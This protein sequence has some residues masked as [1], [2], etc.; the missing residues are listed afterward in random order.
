LSQMANSASMIRNAVDFDVDK[1]QTP[2][3]ATIKR[4]AD[5]ITEK[6]DGDGEDSGKGLREMVL[7]TIRYYRDHTLLGHVY[8]Q[9]IVLINTLSCFQ[10]I[11]L[12][13]TSVDTN[14]ASALYYTFFYVELVVA[15]LFVF[16]F[17]LSMLSSD[18]FL[19]FF[20]SFDCAIDLMTFIPVFATYDVQCPSFHEIGS[21][22]A[23]VYFILCAMTTTRILR[24]IKFRK[25]FFAIEDEVQ[26]FLADMGLKIGVMI[27]FSKQLTV[28]VTGML[29]VTIVPFMVRCGTGAVPR[30]RAGPALPHM[31]VAAV[32]T[33]F[34]C[35]TLLTI[36]LLFAQG[37]T[38]C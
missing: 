32:D 9:F 21:P 33:D 5:Q 26:R 36:A 3:D 15:C 31:Y 18:S 37:C 28:T 11:Y 6:M 29:R 16:D 35:V 10:Y 4:M 2:F 22:K 30:A 14:T 27:L 1:P 25:Y 19:A 12:T 24:S 34:C 13:Y 8:T 7:V 20:Q 23:V 17:I 38:I